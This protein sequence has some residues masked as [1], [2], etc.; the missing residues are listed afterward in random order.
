MAY[1]LDSTGAQRPGPFYVYGYSFAIDATKTVKSITLPDN[2]GVIVLALN[3]VGCGRLGAGRWRHGSR[4]HSGGQRPPP[5]STMDRPSRAA[6][7]DT[8]SYAYFQNL[9]WPIHSLVGRDFYAGRRRRGRCRKQRQHPL[10]RRRFQHPEI[11]GD[12]SER[13]S[14]EPNLHCH[15]YRRDYPPS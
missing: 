9:A 8:H 6:G 3:P 10:A 5:C 13:Q 1:R 2:R 11:I 7:L 12:G 15:L 14:G 4:A